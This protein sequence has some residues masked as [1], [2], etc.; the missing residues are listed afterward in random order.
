M[1]IKRYGEGARIFWGLHG[2]SGDHT[3]FEPLVPF[4]PPD[5]TLYSVDLPG[6]GQSPPAPRWTLTELAN[7]IASEIRKLPAQATLIGNCSGGILGLLALPQVGDLVG[8]LVLIDPFAYVPWYFRLLTSSLI[9]QY[10]YYSTFANPIGRWITNLSLKTHRT[11]ETDLTVSFSRVDHTISY[12][13]LKLLTELDGIERFSGISQPIDI[14]Y[15]ARTFDAIKR[16]IPRWRNL[17]PQAR[18]FELTGAGHLPIREAAENL[19]RI[20]FSPC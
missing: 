4:L 5:V 6:Y 8:R 11:G 16:S 1:F 3:T 2:W 13:Y 12:R 15:G 14:V 20:I 18:T 10:A 9:G 7:E 17:W 19:S